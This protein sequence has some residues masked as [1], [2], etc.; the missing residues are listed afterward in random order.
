MLPKSHILFGFL[1]SIILFFI[2]PQINHTA[3]LIIF[4]ASFLIDV[5]HYL[6]FVF[7]KRKLSL[8][9]A[10]NWFIE[11]RKK[12]QSLS[13]EDVK[14]YKQTIILF[15]GIEFILIFFFLS[16]SHI[17]FFWALIGILFHFILDFYELI[18]EDFPLYVKMS[19]IYVYITN[20]NKKEFT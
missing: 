2:F 7:K 10:Y 17:L 14:K 12:W 20:K 9:K 1:F 18:K 5:D 15:H 8:K 6:Y 13:K 4:L 16:F 19:Q 11:R 3:F